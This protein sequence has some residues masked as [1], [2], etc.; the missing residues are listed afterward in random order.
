M[1]Q[2]EVRPAGPHDVPGIA[3]CVCE[4]YLPYVERIG[5]QPGP[6]VDDYMDVLRHCHVYVAV[7]GR[8]LAGV[9]VLAKTIDGL[10]LDSVAVRPALQGM[11][12]GR[13]LIERAELEAMRLGFD[14]LYMSA[15]EVLDEA[16]SACKRLGYDECERRVDC[17]SAQI[18][19]RKTLRRAWQS[20]SLN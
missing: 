14:S 4:A 3:A 19:L 6:M 15:H 16:I 18:L 20:Y 13:C 2:I 1:D 8:H 7:Q 9:V 17:G 11:G 5:R 10:C 12:I